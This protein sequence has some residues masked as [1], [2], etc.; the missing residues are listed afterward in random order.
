[1]HTLNLS[2]CSDGFNSPGA[3]KVGNCYFLL[4]CAWELLLF[5]SDEYYFLLFLGQMTD[6]IYAEKDLVQS[7]KEYIRAEEKK[8]S[9][10][11]R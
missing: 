5:W 3:F 10:I 6:L 7:L 9:Q 8:L 11:K 2:V 1:M 4:L